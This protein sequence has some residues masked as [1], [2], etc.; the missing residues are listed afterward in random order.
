MI[1]STYK[2]NGGYLLS[3]L[4]RIKSIII[5]MKEKCYIYMSRWVNLYV[6]IKSNVQTIFTYF[7]ISY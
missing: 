6:V 3:W 5:V 1:Y 7:Y 4:G 2:I